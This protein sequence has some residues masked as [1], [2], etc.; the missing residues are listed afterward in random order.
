VADPSSPQAAAF[1]D[2]A[3]KIMEQLGGAPD[4]G[5]SIES[6]VKKIKQPFTNQ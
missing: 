1:R 4:G 2:I 3:K 5:A 6:L